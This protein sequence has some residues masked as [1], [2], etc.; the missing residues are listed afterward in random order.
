MSVDSIK[1]GDVLIEVK[2]LYKSFGENVVMDYIYMEI[3]KDE[4]IYVIGKSG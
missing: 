4:V 1:K 2:N 3:K